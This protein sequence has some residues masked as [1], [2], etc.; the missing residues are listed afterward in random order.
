M[1]RTKTFMPRAHTDLVPRA[2]LL[3]A[4]HAEPGSKLVLVAAPA[5]SGKTALL[6]R[7]VETRSL[8]AVWFS[9]DERSNNPAD[10]V[11]R[12]A[13]ALQELCPA[14][15]SPQVPTRDIAEDGIIQVINTLADAPDDFVLIL[16]NY[17]VIES[18]LVSRAMGLLLDYPPPHLHLIIATQVEPSLPLSRLQVRRQLLRLRL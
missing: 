10:F 12:L 1:L 11:T 16:D 2:R 7:W 5:G 3:E 15:K 13:A 6:R 18:P 14:V 8:P 4:L 17:Q 9:L